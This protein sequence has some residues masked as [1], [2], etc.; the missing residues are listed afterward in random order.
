V[1]KSKIESI[2]LSAAVAAAIVKDG[3]AGFASMGKSGSFLVDIGNTAKSEAK[4]R[5]INGDQ[6]NTLVAKITDDEF[7]QS[8]LRAVLR[9]CETIGKAGKAWQEEHGNLGYQA[10]AS[11]ASA[12]VK[13]GGDVDAAVRDVG[14]KSSARGK[15]K[16]SKA[17]STKA[18]AM[19]VKAMLSLKLLPKE[20][21]S[22]LRDF[23]SSNNI[24]V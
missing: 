24:S 14:K 21:Y 3:K 23:A 2:T 20:F 13:N 4:G 19:H 10:V 8:R 16:P 5:P 18:A 12:L 7:A 9:A 1:T 22:S 17:G 15:V 11:L 6:I